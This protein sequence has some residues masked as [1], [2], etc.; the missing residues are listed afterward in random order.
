[1]NKVFIYDKYRK[2]HWQEIVQE[3][4][5]RVHGALNFEVIRKLI[6]QE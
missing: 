2:R 3:K 5:N 4:R 6:F 1:M